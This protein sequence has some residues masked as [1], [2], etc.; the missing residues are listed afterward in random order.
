MVKRKQQH[1]LEVD[2]RE[3]E[4]TNLDKVLFPAD[5]FTKGDLIDYYVRI[6]PWLLP[7]IADRPMSMH[8][9]PDGIGTGKAFWQKDVPEWAPDWL[10]T[11]RYEAIE[12]KKMLRWGLIDD[13]PSLVWVAN[14]ASIELHPWTSRYDRPEYPDWA[15]FDLDPSEPAGFEECRDI[16]RLLK[17]ALDR[18]ELRSY[19]KTTGQRGLQM[20]VP[21]ARRHKYDVVREWVHTIGELIRQV[22][23]DIVTDQ[24]DTSRRAGKV[25]IDY[26]QMV[27]GKTLVAPYAV[28]PRDGAAVSTPIHWQ[29]LE[30]PNL[31]PDAWTIRTIFDRLDAV[32]DV[33][34][35]A[36]TFDQE[37]PDLAGVLSSE[38]RVPSSSRT[39]RQVLPKKPEPDDKLAPYRRK[40][41]FEVTAEPSGKGNSKLKTQNTEFRFCVQ[42]HHASR[43]HYDFRLEKDGVLLSW[44]VPKGPSLNPADK[45]MAVHVE[46]HPVEYLE[47]EGTIPAGEY[48]GGSVMLWDLGTY[49]E[50]PGSKGNELKFVLH[51]QKLGGEFVLVRTGDDKQW[52]LIKKRDE[53]AGKPVDD[54]HSVKSNRTLDEIA[55]GQ[56]AVWFSDLPAEA[57]ELDLSAVPE[58]PMPRAIEPMMATLAEKAFS[59]PDWLFEVK[60]DGIRAISFV[61]KDGV[62]LMSRRGNNCTAQYPE[63]AGIRRELDAEACIIDGEIVAYDERG[64]PN[65]HLL[66]KRMNLQHAADIQRAQAEI[67]VGMQV[68]DLL[69]LDGRDLRKLPLVQRKALL[70]RIVQPKGFLLYSEHVEGEGKAF[71][72]AAVERGLEGAVA[73]DK[74]SPYITGKRSKHWLKLKAIKEMDCVIGG[75]TE[76]E[77]ARK[78][79]GSVVLGLYQ[80]DGKLCFV[81]NSG[82]G[83]D[84]RT[85]EATLGLLR[86]IEVSKHP[87]VRKPEPP[88]RYHWTE[89]KYVC[90]IKYSN[91]TPEGFVR[92]PV[93]LGLRPDKAPEDCQIESEPP[94]HAVPSPAAFV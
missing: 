43:L 68:F 37:L 34:Q 46:D 3:V 2:G 78:A 81:C 32:G 13:L 28:R 42:K 26:T 35:G 61:T 84:Q 40:R 5:G 85:L 59:H 11:F 93:F 36:L 38:L 30:D 65:F 33:W 23:P 4:V 18:L 54:E 75:W 39:K 8:P 64:I 79:L 69:Y 57:A 58:G 16:A 25:R 10:R 80:A 92:H 24:W 21:I 7:Y 86:P 47:F 22:R 62:R 41:D 19:L 60:W 14:H 53:F 63:L 49:E 31:R 77:G 12:D 72:Q 87:F 73:K 89:P 27:I 56:Q 90:R 6:A 17:V 48:G 66:Q 71:Y 51:G 88:E 45:R 76:G 52:L 67:P 94:S 91:F 15:L 83:F 20:Y 1:F 55:Q 82:S 70:R 29:E 74:N 44:A 9:Y 50:L